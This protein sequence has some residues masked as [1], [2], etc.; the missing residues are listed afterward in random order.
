MTRW[1]ISL[2]AAAMS[3][4][5]ASA[6]HAQN[7]FR[8]VTVPW[9]STAPQ[10]PHD[11]VDGQS[12]YFQAVAQG[13]CAVPIT[14][15]WDYDGDGTWDTEFLP[16]PDRWNLGS[17]Y[18]F[19]AQAETRLYIARVEGACGEA[20]ATA[21]FPI[22]IHV[23]PTLRVEVNRAI[24]NGMWYGH[25]QLT[26]NPANRTAVMIAPGH[27]ETAAS[28]MAQAMMNRGHNAPI[29][30]AVDP[31][32][33]DVT[34][35]IHANL[36]TLGRA[37]IN[38]QPGNVDPDVNGNGFALDVNTNHENYAQGPIAEA[39][40][41]YGDRDYVAPPEVGAPADVAGRRLQ[42]VVQDV[43]EYFFWAQTD[44]AF[45]NGFAGGW[46]YSPN[47]DS[48]DASQVGWAAVFLFAAELEMG[49]V[50]PDWVKERIV[51]G[52][53]QME[54]ANIPGG[55]GYIG[56]GAPPN[57]ARTG[58]MLN[59][60]GFAHNRDRAGAHV[61][62][63][64]NFLGTNFDGELTHSWMGT[65]GKNIGN[66]YAM[67][68]LSKGLRSFD[69]PIDI[70]DGVDWYARYARY[71]VDNQSATGAWENDEAW[72]L[73]WSGR[74]VGLA[75][76]LTLQIL[77]PTLFDTP[78][79]AVADADPQLAG[80]G[81]EITF[82]HNRS[83]ATEPGASLAVYRWNFV[84]YPEGLDLNGD[85]D[86]DDDGEF[87]PED[88]NGD[89]IVDGDEIV[90]E[91]VTAD[92]DA[93]PTYTYSP[94]I[95]FGEEAQFV[96][97]LE[98]EDSEG[99]TD[100]DD[101]SVVIRISIINHPPVAVPHPDG[102]NYTASTAGAVRLDGSASFDPDS[103]DVPAPGFDADTITSYDWDLDGDGIYEAN[104]PIQ[105]FNL[106]E[107]WMPG[108]QRVV[109]LRVCDDGQW[110]GIPDAECDG[111]DCT[112]C[113]ERD[114]VIDVVANAPPVAVV[115][116]NPI[117]IEQGDMAP[118][119]GTDSIDPEGGEL[120]YE[121]ACDGIAIQGD[122]LGMAIVD[123]AAID[124]PA[125]GVN[126]DCTLTVTD[127]LGLTDT[128]PFVVTVLDGDD[129]DDGVTDDND[130]CPAVSNA[131]QADLDG[132][133]LGDACD[134][135]DDNDGI[136]DVDDN[137]P[138]T[139][140]ADQSDID[141]DGLGDV[142]DDDRDDDGVPNDDDNCP[143]IFN[144]GQADLDVDG[145]GDICD[146][147]DDGD[148]VPD[149]DDNC[150]VTA[151]ADQ[152]DL[153]AD[154]LGDVCD[155]DM[156]GDG[157]GEDDNCPLVAN[158]DQADA[159]DDGIGDACDGDTDGDGVPDEDDNCPQIHNDDQLDTDGDGLGDVCDDDD[160]D[161][162]V[163]DGDDNCTLTAN[164]DQ[165]DTDGDGIGDACDDDDDGDGIADDD[166]NCPLTANADQADHDG[167]G[168]GDACDDDRDD[169]GISNDDE[170]AAGTDP[171]DADSDDDGIA[172]G[173][174]ID[175]DQDT[176][177]DGDINANDPDSD[178]DGI[179]D[180]T[181]TGLTEP[182]ADTDGEAGNFVPDADPDTTTDPLDADTD[183][184]G[185]PD[186]EEDLNFDGAIDDGERD[187]NDAV[188]DNDDR[189]G[190]GIANDDEVTAGT[191]PDD[192]DSDDDG[193][194][195]GAETDWDQDSDGD[196]DINA[197]DPDSDND[198]ILDG[199]E[200]GLTE[201]NADT[202]GEAGNFVPDADP[203]TTTDPLDADTD[204]GGIPDGEEDANH[205]GAIDDGEGDPNDPIDDSD[206]PPADEDRDDDGVN[207]GDD[208]CPDVANPQQSDSDGDG[209]GDVCDDDQDNDGLD[210]EEDN[211]VDVANGDQLDS[212]GDG[213]G[214]ACDGES[215]DPT[216]VG[217]SGIGD[218]DCAQRP[219]QAPAPW[220]LLLLLVPVAL[221]RR[222]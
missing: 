191:D 172:D 179:L 120:T 112:L 14:H 147:D 170:D 198:G 108:E 40:A 97:T 117:V 58:S 195:D 110:V 155:D 132:D 36:R 119:D 124:A 85:G 61:E 171:D 121:W 8:V 50:V 176:D 6:A 160:D 22:Q 202:D 205:D 32:V 169:D 98:V 75:T 94:D 177:E 199:T 39:L 19:P 5:A 221:R 64:V 118:A 141:D 129:D 217:G 87:A 15:R 27:A 7:A 71:L 178:N 222:R 29:S 77:I 174:E 34:W 188:D 21:E 180:G 165:L 54:D 48:I 218:G 13:E 190:D 2:A 79:V 55:Y 138:I 26:R 1:K 102:G 209:I 90:W 197:N 95:D 3:C 9:V 201:P 133:G 60:L 11:G 76:G 220:A 153:D 33:E 89:G 151:N 208:N 175:W 185:V 192:A 159:D 130:N 66:L 88:L 49:V 103:N 105:D 143:D 46:S 78:P 41:A 182:N 126:F 142:C 166:D 72:I 187:P 144:D 70:V 80:P 164:L 145:L 73:N 215:T 16:A 139:A 104:G 148:D 68:Q 161:D 183:D 47:S 56:P 44:I 43:A 158:P 84:S 25:L 106:P 189:D 210:D 140:N 122:G 86:F 37:A 111:G 20:R 28:A 65:S 181:E 196:G 81:D 82:R 92:P 134:D 42:D 137:C 93:R 162:T 211:C 96:V 91:F 167:D 115:T 152:A 30:P 38:V 214:D 157:F 163:A 212:D 109:R 206:E 69:P 150:P 101:E 99:R 203:D 35:I 204:D 24:S 131:D 123:A 107:E 125:E 219:G 128:A 149:V 31:Y 186:G 216:D 4:V 168:I 207:D 23:E 136:P 18:T 12:S 57:H 156:D 17:Q 127:D 62:D 193:I 135:D 83:Y 59:A 116:P 100:R 200:T 52:A 67:Y 10:V 113:A 213:L 184:G 74:H 173:D 51:L 114:V 63:A 53:E 45:N 154:G 146:P 194:A